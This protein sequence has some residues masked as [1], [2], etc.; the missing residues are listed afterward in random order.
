MPFD[1]ILATAMVLAWIVVLLWRRRVR[2]LFFVVTLGLVVAVA[3]AG[4]VSLSASPP[5]PQQQQGIPLAGVPG[6]ALVALLNALVGFLC[7]LGLVVLNVVV[8]VI[9]SVA[10]RPDPA[11]DR[12]AEDLWTE[13]K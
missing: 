7:W 4:I 2:P 10:A 8:T 3:A 6:F 12:P 5:V 11:Q 1:W 13:A 9:R